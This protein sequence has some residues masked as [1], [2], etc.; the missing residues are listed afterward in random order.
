MRGLRRRRCDFLDIGMQDLHMP[1][2][3]GRS[4][5][6]RAHAGSAHDTHAGA[7]LCRQLFKQM[8]GAGERAGQ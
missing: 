8:L 5:V 7:K 1:D 6:A 2:R 3:A 4:A